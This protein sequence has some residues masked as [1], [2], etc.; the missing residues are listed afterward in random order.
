MIKS[1][2]SYLK[3]SAVVAVLAIALIPSLR[4]STAK[5]QVSPVT[6][7]ADLANEQ[8]V[9]AKYFE[10]LIAYADEVVV[11]DKKRASL[12]RADLDP[13]QRKSDDLKGRLSAVQNSVREIVRKLKAANEWEDLDRNVSA[14]ITDAGQKSLFQQTSFKRLLED[15]SNNLS[16]H[17]NEISAP[18]DNLRKR[19]T[20]RYGGAELQ[21]VRAGYESPALPG[22]PDSLGCTIGKLGL[23]A[24]KLA[25][26]KPTNAA[27]D[28]VFHQ[29][30]PAGAVSP[31]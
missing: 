18:L 29:C 9:I 17:G 23:V 2:F 11:Q 24:I 16:S 31:F 25:G 27:F 30:W 7:G 8:R 5:N 12:L 13:L 26:G 6:T 3:V 22:A 21:I 19:L 10:D 14:T 15:S 28:A 1:G 20:S 4:T